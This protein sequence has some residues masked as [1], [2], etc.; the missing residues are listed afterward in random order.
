MS[1]LK[2]QKSVPWEHAATQK[3]ALNVSV[4]MDS[5]C[6]PLEEGAKVIAFEGF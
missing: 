1:V 6:P 4:Q 2:S 5:P 3:A